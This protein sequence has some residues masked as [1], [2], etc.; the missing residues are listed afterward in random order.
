MYVCALVWLA[1][2]NYEARTFWNYRR[3]DVRALAQDILATDVLRQAPARID[4]Y[5]SLSKGSSAISG[6]WF[7]ICCFS[8]PGRRPARPMSPHLAA[9]RTA[10]G[11]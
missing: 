5:T 1:R 9:V 6:G 3:S 4:Q 8:V 10:Y 2:T 11:C 7:W